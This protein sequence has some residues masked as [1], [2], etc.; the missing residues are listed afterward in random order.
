MNN[1]AICESEYF[2]PTLLLQPRGRTKTQNNR[3][4]EELRIKLETVLVL[5]TIFEDCMYCTIHFLTVHVVRPL[6]E[7]AVVCVSLYPGTLPV[8][9]AVVEVGSIQPG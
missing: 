5:P 6:G 9:S 8:A 3:R 7:Y 4:G 2:C 1:F